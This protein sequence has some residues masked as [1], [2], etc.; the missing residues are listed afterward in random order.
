MRGKHTIIINGRHY[1]ATTGLA[2]DTPAVQASTAQNKPVA[3]KT[4]EHHIEVKIA[5]SSTPRTAANHVKKH[6]LKSQ[7]LRRDIVKRPSGAHD[8]V[9]KHVTTHA[10]VHKSP[11]ISKF[12]PH[13]ANVAPRTTHVRQHDTPTA[14]SH[15][16][17]A[18]HHKAMARTEKPKALS[19]RELKDHLIKQRLDAA[20]TKHANHKPTK[21][22]RAP[23][24]VSSVM[25]ACL[26]VM[27]LG[28]YLSYINM[29]NLSVRVAASQAGINAQYPGYTPS[30]YRFNGPVS[31]SNG[32]VLLSFAANG[33]NTKYQI[34][35]QKS[36]WDSQA[37]LDNY[38]VAKSDSYDV[39]DT[40]GLTVYTYG[41]NAAW[42]NK[43]V[44]YTIS[45]DAPLRTEQVLRIA[46]SL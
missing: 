25:A 46:T 39:N 42:V 44:L 18:A 22:M 9:A 17:T 3:T 34:N 40:Q 31:Y 12:A 35:Q 15:V 36:G 13:P 14:Q 29:P 16:V 20:P 43:G 19:S 8:K 7:T 33:G 4:T 6:L 30:G 27:I 24:R 10:V 1:D 41:N 26:G 11:H 38:V 2:V 28:G 32:Q 23:L 37:V 5:S 45:G 21:K